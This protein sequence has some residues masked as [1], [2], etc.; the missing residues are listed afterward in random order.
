[1]TSLLCA[2]ACLFAADDVAN[3]LSKETIAAGK[4]LLFDG[5]SVFG[6]TGKEA[7]AKDGALVVPAGAVAKTTTQ[8]CD[9]TLSFEF[10]VDDAELLLGDVPHALKSPADSQG[11]TALS[12]TIRGGEI[13]REPKEAA[14]PGRFAIGFRAGKKPLELRSVVYL[15]EGL[16]PIFNGK[17]LDGW[18]PIPAKKSKFS[19]TP[20]GWLNVKD[21]PGDLQTTGE[22]DDFVLQLDVISNGKHLNSGIFYRAIAGENWSGY[23]SQI[24]N[25]WEGEDRT[26]PVDFGTG[27]I[28]RRQKTRKVN[29][30]DGEW[31]TKTVI[32]H[33]QHH[34]V[35][36]N[37][38]QVADYTDTAPLNKSARKGS[39]VEKGPIS[40]QGHDPTTDLSFRNLKLV[41]LPK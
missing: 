41:E 11:W 40:I 10:K 34:A 20:E 5:E 33:G 16:K 26:K 24:R 37:G 8:F 4:I 19:V 14:K 13:A 15:P 27:G 22:W 18:K 35:W 6:W 23:E 9:G 38:L 21:G 29:A 25:Q 28:Y 3:V 30:T 17:D 36:V 31:F 7:S 12:F 39:K 32:A 2:A 1:M